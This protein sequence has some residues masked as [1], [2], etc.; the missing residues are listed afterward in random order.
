MPT[1]RADRPARRL[2]RAL[3]LRA[4]SRSQQ[5]QR[6]AAADYSL[7]QAAALAPPRHVDGDRADPHQVPGRDARRN[8]RARRGAVARLLFSAD[9]D[10]EMKLRVRISRDRTIERMEIMYR[11]ELQTLPEPARKYMLVALEAITDIDSWARMR[12]LH[13]LSNTGPSLKERT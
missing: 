4:L 10:E 5:A 13:G 8:L 7:A 2:F 1:A 3:D 9:Q 6:I 11:P 12:E